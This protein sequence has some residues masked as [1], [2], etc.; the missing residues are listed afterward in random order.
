MLRKISQEEQ[1]QALIRRLKIKTEHQW[2]SNIKKEIKPNNKK[3][4]FQKTL[5]KNKNGL[6]VIQDKII[7]CIK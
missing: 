2:E 1:D 5:F 3:I 4:K 7:I 6:R